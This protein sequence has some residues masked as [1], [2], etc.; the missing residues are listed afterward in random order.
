MV[1]K[2]KLLTI[3]VVTVFAMAATADSASAQLSW[4]LR[5]RTPHLSLNI[6]TSRYL[7][8]HHIYRYPRYYPGYSYGYGYGYGGP[9]YSI[10]LRPYSPVAYHYPRYY[11]SRYFYHGYAPVYSHH[12]VPPY[13]YSGYPYYPGLGFTAQSGLGYGYGNLSQ[14]GQPVQV[15][16]QVIIQNNSGGTSS[17]VIVRQSRSWDDGLWRVET[18]STA[19][20]SPASGSIRDQQ[21]PAGPDGGQADLPDAD[22]QQVPPAQPSQPQSDRPEGQPNLPRPQVTDSEANW[23]HL[24][25]RGN[26][27]ERRQA[28][29]EL[30]RYPTS[31]SVAALLDALK[32]DGDANVRQQ[33]AFTL[34]TMLAY[35]SLDTLRDVARTDRDTDV[36]A[37]ALTA[38]KKIEA[39]YRI[40]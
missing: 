14:D 24:I 39:F 36:R 5:Y 40:D 33:A 25:K 34:G 38:A 9:A 16:Q 3:A 20:D 7:G 22:S 23:L 10:G 27:A 2:L 8:L 12:L 29:R 35:E 26:D 17:K 30:S 11:S 31:Q 37:T 19:A 15:T 6:G 4:R 13:Y 32:R 28:A 18:Y 21:Q 1:R